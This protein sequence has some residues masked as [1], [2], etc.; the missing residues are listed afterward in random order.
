MQLSQWKGLISDS[1]KPAMT[2]AGNTLSSEAQSGWIANDKKWGLG[3][4]GGGV[5]LVD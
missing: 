5:S 2:L 4:K 3:E 1:R